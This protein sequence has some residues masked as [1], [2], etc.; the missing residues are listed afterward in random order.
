MKLIFLNPAGAWALLGVPALVIIHCLRVRARELRIAALFLVEKKHEAAPG[1]KFA[2]W[3]GSPLFW[4]QLLAILLLSFLLCAPRFVEADSRREVAIVVDASVS[5]RAF[6]AGVSAGASRIADKLSRDA[7]TT[8]WLL[9][10]TDAGSPPLY[11]G[12]DRAAMLRALDAFTPSLGD[13]DFTEAVVTAR[14]GLGAG[15]RVV[16]LT[17]HDMAAVPGGA[18]LV[19]VGKPAD[20]V[21]F[22][23]GVFSGPRRWRALVVNH[24]D[25]P[26]TRRWWLESG[27][28]RKTEPREL[29]LEP[30]GTVTLEGEAP[31]EAFSVMLEADAFTADDRLP[32]VVPVPKPLLWRSSA[33]ATLSPVVAPALAALDYAGPAAVAAVAD[34][35]IVCAKTRDLPKGSSGAR[36]LFLDSDGEKTTPSKSSCFA[37]AAHPLTDGLAWGLVP[38][39]GTG[40]FGA[41]PGD[42]VLVR[43]GERALVVLGRTGNVDELVFNYDP[44]LVFAGEKLP[45]AAVLIR[46]FAETVRA[47]KDAPE[48]LN[49]DCRAQLPTPAGT[50]ALALRD[51]AGKITPVADGA[52]LRAP[53]DAGFFSVLR[54]DTVKITGGAAFSDTREADLTGAAPAEKLLPADD[55]RV[56]GESVLDPLAVAGVLALLALLLISWRVAASRHAE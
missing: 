56:R 5:M 11:V 26:A 36:I 27:D 4:I 21:G 8:H 29:H 15:G 3:R 6:R 38:S 13:H 44:R 51:A 47:A 55:A 19:S 54:G 39:F 14:R 12:E 2:K 9:V 17:D 48:S 18:E 7:A 31:A 30:R 33:P 20:N 32:L 50:G 37:P 22:S 40:G 53:G 34:L 25:A 45:A 42:R 43:S 41:A 16:L 1:S 35:D 24:A 52:V 28:G 46:R 23:G 49:T 10:S